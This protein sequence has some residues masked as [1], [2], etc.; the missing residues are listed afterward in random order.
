MA[1]P[2]QF[3]QQYGGLA[4]TIGGQLGVDP[5]ILLGQWGLET[6]WGK[7]VIP[8][9]NNLGNIK[10]AGVAAVDNQ[11]GSNDQYRA[12]GS[13]DEFGQDFAGLIG[14]RYQG[15]MN[16]GEDAQKYA[17][18]LASGGYA[19]DPQYADKLVAAAN[20]VRGV[21]GWR[22]MLNQAANAIFPSA[23]AAESDDI[24]SGAKTAVPKAADT[25]DI[26]AGAKTAAPRVSTSRGPDGVLRV[27]MGNQDAPVTATQAQPTPTPAA[28]AAASGPADAPP[29][30][31]FMEGLAR[32]LGLT[33]RYGIEGVG[34]ALQ[35]FTEPLR[36]GMVNP[37]ARAVGLPE[38]AP[39][40]KA[41]SELAGSVGLPKPETKQE[42]VVGDAAR[43]MAG[44][45][46]GFGAAKLLEAAPG[47][48]GQL[49]GLLTAGP[50][51]QVASATGTGLLG[52]VTKENGSG[53]LG[54]AGGALL[55]GLAGAGLAS[56]ANAGLSAGKSL[57]SR[58]SPADIDVRLSNALTDA[59]VDASTLP[60]GVL[61]ALKA[62]MASVLRTGRELRPD[63]V[64]RLADFRTVGATPTR[65][66][67]TLD[68]VQITR[69]QN[70]A[71]IA[72]NTSDDQLAAL[73]RIQNANNATLIQRLNEAGADK[74][75]PFQ[76]GSGV[77]STILNRDAAA[78]SHVTDLYNRARSMAGGDIPL[79]RAPVINGVFD[80]LAK[81]NKLAFLPDNIGSMLNQIS[82]GSVRVGDQ[83]HEVPF[84]AQVLDNLKTMLATAQ[85]GTQDGNVKAA[86]AI[87]RRAIDA[88]EPRP[89]T[90]LPPG[91]VTGDVASVLRNVD[92][93]SAAYMDALNQ[94][95]AAS[96]ARF[97]WQESS[98]PVEAA[99]AGAQ[100]D[101][102]VQ[103]FVVN[104]DLTDARAVVANIGPAEKEAVR[105]SIVG[106]LRDK[107]LNGASDEVGKFSQSAYN[108][109][110]KA[111]GDRKLQLFFT[112][113]EI[114]Q[115]KAVGRVASY[116]QAQPV[117]SAVN[118]SNSG[119]LL[120][121]RGYDLMRSIAG[122]IPFG[123]AAI[124]NPLRNIE[125]SIR[126]GQ[127][128]NIMPGL[129]AQ[130][131]R[132]TPAGA[133]LLLPA[134]SLGGLLAAPGVPSP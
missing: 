61:R 55:G 88:A 46:P 127:A 130:T 131:Q 110:I 101:K 34:N 57:L 76:A 6:G 26:F 23:Q 21:S 80:A 75:D 85:R 107:A 108:R 4:D 81:E 15:V 11:T 19:E 22:G 29:E 41:A 113:Q 111:I 109:A 58:V 43:L 94:A 123:E 78:Q 30:R 45:A 49:G 133:S 39:T 95:R 59:G 2:Q 60:D 87:A 40:G 48:A 124:L 51:A 10:G 36:A 98:K 106:H 116:L 117:G 99:L 32:Q 14:R 96:K 120:A 103:K 31:T 64:R 62:E 121:G 53:P 119:A 90:G 70:L 83:V 122:K 9:T 63:A 56:A 82:K 129:L 1:N 79:E 35:L 24:F 65:G 42:R 69:E 128:Q 105:N 67:I 71:K 102:F 92:E 17:R 134:A 74:A 132:Q 44:V 13:P 50:G 126:Q 91:I 5:S 27:E 93:S 115:L 12:Y 52:G 38:A 97:N 86:L 112:P 3:V 18:A 73:P 28:P 8:G 84:N 114:T 33:A 104:G 125:I 66:A 20:A 7:S 100:P 68:P 118:N 16:V 47:L 77:I 54:Q 25:D 89:A 72:A 37:I